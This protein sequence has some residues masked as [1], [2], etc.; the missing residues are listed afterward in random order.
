VRPD[1]LI[2]VKRGASGPLEFAWFPRVFPRATLWVANTESFEAGRMRGMT[3]E[4]LLLDET[5]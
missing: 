5:W 2:E 1:F 4:D 3:I